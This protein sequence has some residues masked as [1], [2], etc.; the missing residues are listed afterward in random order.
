MHPSW[1]AP[2]AKG[3]RQGIAVHL[4]AKLKDKTE[5]FTNEKRDARSLWFTKYPMML[6]TKE[7]QIAYKKG[8]PLT[9]VIT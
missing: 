3:H 5:K 6:P 8:H 9:C 2:G 1:G 4:H 7:Y